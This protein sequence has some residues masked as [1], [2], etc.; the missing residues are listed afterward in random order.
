MSA[1]CTGSAS[2]PSA[3]R[4]SAPASSSKQGTAG[5]WRGRAWTVAG[6]R[7]DRG[8]GGTV[9][10]VALGRRAERARRLMVH[11]Q[12]GECFGVPDGC[13]ALVIVEVGVDGSLA[14]PGAGDALRPRPQ[15]PRSVA[16]PLASPSLIESQVSPAPAPPT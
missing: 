6:P 16:G 3:S 13:T 12:P 15:R 14:R 8:G 5:R 1:G 4:P 9:P 10:G 7:L 2:T 11:D